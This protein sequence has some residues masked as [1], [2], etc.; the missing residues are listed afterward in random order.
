MDD[1]VDGDCVG[2]LNL[3]S[4]EFL[5]TFLILLLGKVFLVDPPTPSDD[6]SNNA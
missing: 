5:L 2:M 3:R 4:S 6:W 1:I